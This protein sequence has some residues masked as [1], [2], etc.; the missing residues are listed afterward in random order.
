MNY[1]IA[2]SWGR[3]QGTSLHGPY[4]QSVKICSYPA[5][6][7]I[8]VACAEIWNFPLVPEAPRTHKKYDCQLMPGRTEKNNSFGPNSNFI[9][10]RDFSG[11]TR[12]LVD[13]GRCRTAS[14]EG[15]ILTK[16]RRQPFALAS[17]DFPRAQLCVGFFCLHFLMGPQHRKNSA[18]NL[19]FRLS[20]WIPVLLDNYIYIES[21]YS[22][23]IHYIWS[24]LIH[25]DPRWSCRSL[26]S[27][28]E[29]LRSA[30][31]GSGRGGWILWPWLDAQ[32]ASGSRES[33]SWALY[34]GR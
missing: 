21:M 30:R 15:W 9:N 26:V 7:R 2:G 29:R 24:I 34:V 12:F 28:H 3:H 14:I 25:Y 10:S 13:S 8:F 1:V 33:H 5:V 20:L 17:K 6:G 27:A 22:L 23:Y 16:W 32:A 11:P 18:L 31:T 4:C 19:V